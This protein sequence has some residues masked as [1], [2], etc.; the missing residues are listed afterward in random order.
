MLTKKILVLLGPRINA[1][2]RLDS[3]DI[4]VDL[5]LRQ[6]PGEAIA[7]AQEINDI[8]IKRQSIVDEI[9]KEA[10]EE[11]N[12]NEKYKDDKVIIIGK[13]GW[14]AGVI[15]IVASRLVETFS[16]PTIVFSFDLEQDLL[17]DLLEVYR[18]LICLK[19]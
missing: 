4:G 17:K 2:G 7:I 12:E 13:P 6:K 9:A 19:I 8:N 10:I 15:G 1:P 3:A 16:K 5:F 14:N 11:F 18:N